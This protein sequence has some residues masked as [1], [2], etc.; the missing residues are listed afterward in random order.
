VNAITIQETHR[1]D[2]L[3]NA[4]C[5]LQNIIL[6]HNGADNWKTGVS[7]GVIKCDVEVEDDIPVIENDFSYILAHHKNDKEWIIMQNMENQ[8]VYVVASNNI[9]KLKR[10]CNINTGPAQRMTICI[11]QIVN[12]SDSYACR[13]S[14]H[15]SIIVPGMEENGWK[16]KYSAR[17]KSS[18]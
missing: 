12:Y 18:I 15:H 13:L 10:M 2:Q 8:F 1:L 14:W 16:V 17:F 3:F 5:V 9:G 7:H 6:D 11:H 4:C